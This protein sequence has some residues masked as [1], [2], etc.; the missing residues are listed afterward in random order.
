MKT[1]TLLEFGLD[2]R[3]DIQPEEKIKSKKKKKAKKKEILHELFIELNK[4]P[5]MT[6]KRII[7]HLSPRETIVV[8]GHVI[9]L[10]KVILNGC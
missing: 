1:E 10:L 9:Y 7:K 2:G 6:I 8:E 5:K 3:N 4:L